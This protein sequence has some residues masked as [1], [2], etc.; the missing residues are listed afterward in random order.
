MITITIKYILIIIIIL[1]KIIN[2]NIIFF[3]KVS[4]IKILY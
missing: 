1:L 4:K 2:D 3:E